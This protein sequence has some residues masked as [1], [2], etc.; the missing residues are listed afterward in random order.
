MVYGIVHRLYIM[1]PMDKRKI[2]RTR[3]DNFFWPNVFILS[4]IYYIVS[5]YETWMHSSAR[6]VHELSAEHGHWIWV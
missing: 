1:G 5:F 3:N 2:Q 6:I 4:H